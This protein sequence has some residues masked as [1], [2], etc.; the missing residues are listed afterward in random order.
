MDFV[1]RAIKKAGVDENDPLLHRHNTGGKV[2][3]GP[4][5]FIHHA[6]LD[7]VTLQTQQVLDGVEQVVGESDFFRSVHLGFDDI[8]RTL[9][10]VAMAAKARQILHGN[11]A[12]DDGVHD[13]FGDF[14]PVRQQDRRIGHQMA[15]IADE[16]QAAP[17][18]RQITTVQRR[19]FPI[20][21]QFAMQDLAAL[22]K[23]FGQI[24][25]HQAQ[26]VGISGN[27]VL[28]IDGGDRSSRSQIV[29]SADRG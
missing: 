5:F 13:A 23:A 28:G 19:P 11:R 29:V 1:T 18:Q 3:A 12:G 4:A 9:A 25:P 14:M 21:R 8:D 2:G 10:A 15:D 24:A 17:G 6:D 16:Q 22:F 26:P 7:R 20:R 27:L